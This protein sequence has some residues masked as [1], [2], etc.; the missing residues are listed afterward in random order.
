MTWEERMWEGRREIGVER[1][2]VVRI[3]REKVG[4]SLGK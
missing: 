4:G 3:V 1:R 2:R